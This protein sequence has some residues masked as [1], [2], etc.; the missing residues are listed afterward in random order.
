MSP[1][2]IQGRT[3]LIVAQTVLMGIAPLLVIAQ[4]PSDAN[5]VPNGGTS[6]ASTP[7]SPWV[8]LEGTYQNELKK[9]HV[10]LISAYVNDLQRLAASS[11]NAEVTV[12][13]EKELQYLQTV[14]SSGGVVEL[15]EMAAE[16]TNGSTKPPAP[17][18]TPRQATNALLV[19]T[20]IQASSITPPSATSNL[21]DA[22]EFI[23]M[24]W[25]VEALPKG[26]YEIIAQCSVGALPT[27]GSLDLSLGRSRL[28]FDLEKRHL[29]PAPDSFRLLKLGIIELVVDVK[30]TQ[31]EITAPKDSQIKLR[32]LLITQAKADP[33]KAV[34]P[35][36]P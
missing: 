12:A 13:I 32:Q 28:S 7:S 22:V 5:P 18:P 8:Q 19:F 17:P 20:P 21:A 15:S 26:R 34:P 33:P 36:A 14:I 23:N 29:A 11:S 1:K 2:P 35:P 27:L 10:P 16:L 24:T 25:V 31:I 4:S 6:S 3:L 9:I 30:D